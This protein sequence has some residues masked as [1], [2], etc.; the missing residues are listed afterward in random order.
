[1]LY[2]WWVRQ[3]LEEK[4]RQGL[5]RKKMKETFAPV[6]EEDDDDDARARESDCL[7]SNAVESLRRGLDI[8]G[9]QANSRQRYH[10]V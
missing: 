10:R 1:M 7:K 3:R 6:V 5:S 9:M 2:Y 4:S 8:L